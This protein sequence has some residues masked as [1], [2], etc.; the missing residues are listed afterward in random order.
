MQNHEMLAV[1]DF[2]R[3][4]M[5]ASIIAQL[6]RCRELR[7]L[8]VPFTLSPRRPWDG[9]VAALV[10]LTIVLVWPFLRLLPAREPSRLRGSDGT[11]RPASA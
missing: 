8:D 1:G 4:Q 11:P 6:R 2:G 7:Q 9:G 3:I 10:S 5:E